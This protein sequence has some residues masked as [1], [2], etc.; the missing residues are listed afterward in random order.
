MLNS[1]KHKFMQIV[2]NRYPQVMAGIS[3]RAD[4]SMVWGNSLPVDEVVGKNRNRYF[5]KL[6]IDPKQVVAGGIAHGTH[7]AAVGE[8]EAGK[9]LLNTDALITNVPN[10]FLT[11]TVAD[12][13]PVFY[14]DPIKKVIGMAHAG[15]RGLVNGVLEN[16]VEKLQQSYGS[17]PQDL[18]VVVGPHIKSCHYE[19]GEEVAAQFSQQNIEQRNGHLFVSLADEAVMRLEKSGVKH[20]SVSPL[21]TYDETERFYSARHDKT[22]PLQGMLAYIGLRL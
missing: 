19:K 2:F 20:I 10:L 9:Y 13:L 6:G 7:V 5:E 16:L 15:W 14:Y 1:I 12:C 21:C 3:E 17:S 22:E 4:G 11:I 8:K 18:L